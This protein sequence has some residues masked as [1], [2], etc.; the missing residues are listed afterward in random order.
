[1][2][3]EGTKAPTPRR[4]QNRRDSG[5]GPSLGQPARRFVVDRRKLHGDAISRH[6][7]L[8]CKALLGSYQHA[9]DKSF[10]EVFGSI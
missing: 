8:T 9:I 1:M 2:S 4:C 5:S 10:L 7:W 6:E 3:N